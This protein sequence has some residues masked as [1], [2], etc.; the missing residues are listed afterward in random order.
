MNLLYLKYAVEIASCGSLNKAA[1]KLYVG[2]PN[3]SRALKELEASLGVSIFERSA[4]GMIITPDGEIFLK[5]AQNILSQVDSVE[6]MFKD[7]TT[8]KKRFA[9]SGPRSSYISEAFTEFS[10]RLAEE[11]KFEA[12][13]KE[14]NSMKTLKN[15]LQGDFKLGI[16]RYAEAFDHYYKD[17][18][19]EKELC[20]EL[21]TEFRYVLL[22]GKDSPLAKKD[23]LTYA[24]LAD[25][26][27]IAHADPYVPSLPLSEVKKEEIPEVKRRIYVYERASQFSLL[28]ENRNTF[29]WVSPVPQKILEQYGLV[30]CIC[31]ENRKIY[32]DVI[33]YQNNYK[34]TELDKAFISEL[35]RVKREVID[36]FQR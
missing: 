6:H 34:L 14:T 12:F 13:Y 24:D 9:V 15:V 2:Q 36:T 31:N 21:I 4:K 17:A 20:Y 28:S 33:I 35:C 5:Y 23:S 10:K 29:M 26:I 16:V 32:K 30:Q 8:Q 25:Y 11:E 27:E 19:D 3:L 1:E 22:M 18:F 7:G